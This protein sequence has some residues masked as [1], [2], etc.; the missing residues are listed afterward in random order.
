[1][2]ER[3]FPAGETIFSEGDASGEAFIIHSGRVEILKRTSGDPI[4][5]AVLGPG[6]VLGE[7]G[8]LEERPRSAT[9]RTLDEVT[10]EA[11]EREEFLR[12]LL[13]EPSEAMGLLR[14]LFERL[15]SVNQM[16]VNAGLEAKAAHTPP[17][18]VIFAQDEEGNDVLPEAGIEVRRFPFRIGR[19]PE[20][21]EEEALAFNDVTLPDQ[22]PHRLSLNHFALD[23]DGSE[24]I[25]RDR[26]SRQG[27]LINGAH[28]AGGR[29]PDQ[30]VLRDGYND[31]EIHTAPSN[32]AVG[33]AYRFKILVQQ[34]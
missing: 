5:L 7:M 16:L 19:A 12:L 30:A 8:L 9:A 15:R 27:M 10:L 3:H 33:K 29:G 26:G 22:S 4:R 24:V 18:V 11:V 1:M 23:M 17:R 21:R 32:F 31:V 25:V 28:V 14:A 6:D 34:P 2:Q 13:D 20:S